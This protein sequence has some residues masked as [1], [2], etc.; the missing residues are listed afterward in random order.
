MKHTAYKNA[1]ANGAYGA[2]WLDE[3]TIASGGA[4]GAVRQVRPWSLRSSRGHRPCRSHLASNR[5]HLVGRDTTDLAV[6]HPTDSLLECRCR[7]CW[8][9]R[10]SAAL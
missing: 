8:V 4:D 3:R 9:A 1:H 5:G 6:L 10:P 7:T 2:V